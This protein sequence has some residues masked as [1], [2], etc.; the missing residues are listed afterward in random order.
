MQQSGITPAAAVLVTTVQSL[1]NKGEGDFERGLPNVGKHIQILQTFG[2]PAIAAINRF[3]NDSS[4]DLNRLAAYC[5]ERGVGSAL[6][7]GFAKGGPGAKAL[8]EQVVDAIAKTP[9]PPVH[10]L[11]SLAEPLMA[12]TQTV[13]LNIYRAVAV[14]FSEQAKAK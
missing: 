8:A 3:P 14:N 6:S 1:R 9:V 12:K 4:A 11:Y 10:P 13:A 2:V 7:E 5:S